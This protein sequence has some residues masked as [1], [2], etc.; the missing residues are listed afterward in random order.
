[1]SN[2]IGATWFTSSNIGTVANDDA[3]SGMFVRPAIM[4]DTRR[5][6][7]ME[8][9]RD[10]SLRQYEINVTAGYAVGI[11]RD[12]FGAGIIADAAAPS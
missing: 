5:P 6:M 11:V 9:Q 12:T 10:A 4:L 8:P 1:M 2:M 7:R 3:Y